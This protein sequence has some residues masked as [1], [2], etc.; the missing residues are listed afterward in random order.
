MEHVEGARLHPRNPEFEWGEGV[1]ERGP[2]RSLNINEPWNVVSFS[3]FLS[4]SFPR[5][6]NREKRSRSSSSSSS[7]P[8]AIFPSRLTV[9]WLSNVSSFKVGSFCPPYFLLLLFSSLLSLCCSLV[10]LSLPSSL[11]LLLPLCLYLCSLPFSVFPAVTSLIMNVRRYLRATSIKDL[12]GGAP[13]CFWCA[14]SAFIRR[15]PTSSTTMVEE[16]SRCENL[17]C[18]LSAFQ[19]ICSIVNGVER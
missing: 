6:T 17:L 13:G 8:S 4:P 18:I 2:A 3:L 7:S 1:V 19:L 12:N 15:W 16:G 10:R 14:A 5:K 9:E 11:F